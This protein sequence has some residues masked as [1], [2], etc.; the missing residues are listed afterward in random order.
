MKCHGYLLAESRVEAAKRIQKRAVEQLK[1]EVVDESRPDT[2]EVVRCPRCLRKMAKRFV[3]APASLTLDICPECR[4]VW[5]DG[6]ELARLQLSHEIS[7][8][9]RDAAER[10]RRLE[11]MTPEAKAEF[12]RNLAK[13]KADDGSL[14]LLLREA[15]IG[16]GQHWT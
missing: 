4:H 7:P 2:K 5:L 10:R 12:E 1:Q 8:G 6:G 14:A 3:D 11:A 15:L 16:G 9:G 13:L